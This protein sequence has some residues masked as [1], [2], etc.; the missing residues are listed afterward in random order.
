MGVHDLLPGD[1]GGGPP[2]QRGGL[3][4]HQEEQSAQAVSIQYHN[5]ITYRPYHINIP[6]SCSCFIAHAL[7]ADSGTLL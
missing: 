5:Y 7:A 3:H 4:G 2:R 6:E 1:L